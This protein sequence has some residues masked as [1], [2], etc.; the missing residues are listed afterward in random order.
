[1][2]V[3]GISTDR[4]VLYMDTAAPVPLVSVVAESLLSPDASTPVPAFCSLFA[5]CTS[6]TAFRVADESCHRRFP[7]PGDVDASGITVGYYSQ[8]ATIASPERLTPA[9]SLLLSWLLLLAAWLQ[10]QT[11]SLPSPPPWPRRQ[12]AVQKPADKLS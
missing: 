11:S 8:S 10:A 9:A 3:P 6:G 12:T 5:L 2:P 1:M 7:L 4:T